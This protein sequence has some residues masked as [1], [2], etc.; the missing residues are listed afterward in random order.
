MV[1]QDVRELKKDLEAYQVPTL[2]SSVGLY[3]QIDQVI[4]TGMNG[5]ITVNPIEYKG[6]SVLLNPQYMEIDRIYPFLFSGHNLAA[7]KQQDETIHFY[8]NDPCV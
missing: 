3:G 2:S 5:S 4:A 6:E 8:S 1:L 7:V